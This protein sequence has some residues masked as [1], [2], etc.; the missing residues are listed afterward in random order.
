MKTFIN[1]ITFLGIMA[2]KKE[3]TNIRPIGTNGSMLY[4]PKAIMKKW[5]RQ[6]GDTVE[7]SIEN[8]VLV[9]R[10]VKLRVEAIH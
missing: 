4:L 2:G 9:A 6:N 5:E 8:G 1:L 3:I 7:L 10:P